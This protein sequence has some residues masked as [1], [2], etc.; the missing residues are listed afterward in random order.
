MQTTDRPKRTFPTTVVLSIVSGRLLC[1]SFGDMH[2]LA[3][4]VAGHPIWTHEFAEQSLSDRLRR[5]LIAQHPVLR[6]T[7]LASLGK[8]NFREWTDREVAR[9]GDS[10]EITKGNA[11]R[12]EGPAQSL[13]RIAHSAPDA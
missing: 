3:E 1:E 13:D 12:V 6:G 2:E 4:Y 11:R 5:E 10:L 9:V 7:D 8:D